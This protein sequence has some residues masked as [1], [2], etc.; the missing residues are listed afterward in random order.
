MTIRRPVP[1]DAAELGELHVRAWQEAYG[2]GLMPASYLEGLSID[3][4]IEGWREALAEEPR[5]GVTRLVADR[6]GRVVGFIVVGPYLEEAVLWVHPEN[7]LARGFYEAAGWRADGHQRWREIQGA[8][9]PEARYHRHLAAGPPGG[10][11]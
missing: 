1:D 11:T 5:P 7:A 10:V 3:E 9:I 8:E 2:D 6:A 4:R